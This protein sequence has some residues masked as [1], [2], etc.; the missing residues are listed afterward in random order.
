MCSVLQCLLREAALLVPDLRGRGA[1]ARLR[2]VRLG[3]G[4]GGALGLRRGQVLSQQGRHG[5][6][7]AV[8]LVAGGRF[9]TPPPL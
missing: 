9:G 8:R 5:V 7:Y 3:E 6:Q 4:G 2:A 1:E